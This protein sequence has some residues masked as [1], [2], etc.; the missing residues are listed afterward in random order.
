MNVWDQCRSLDRSI[1]PTF[2]QKWLIL[3]VAR[4][5]E[6]CDGCLMCVFGFVGS[7]IVA[8][9]WLMFWCKVFGFVGSKTVKLTNDKPVISP[10]SNFEHTVHVGFDPHTGEFTVSQ[11][12]CWMTLTI[13][14]SVCWF[15]LS[16]TLC[17]WYYVTAILVF[18]MLRSIS[19]LWQD[20]CL[21]VLGLWWGLCKNHL[22][23][24]SQQRWP[25]W[26]Q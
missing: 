11:W 6:V 8:S 21:T 10:P 18:G 20:M 2:D 16:F 7:R 5:L 14:I 24:G 22:V 15:V 19:Q 1:W 26:P 25:Q 4:Q 12:A 13:N 23:A 9:T 3:Q 17:L